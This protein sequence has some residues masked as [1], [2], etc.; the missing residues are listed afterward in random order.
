MRNRIT[1]IISSPTFLLGLGVVIRLFWIFWVEVEQS[2]D[3]LWY[4]QAAKGIAE[5]G[6]YLQEGKATAFF[7]VGYPAF[8]SIFYA[9]FGASPF[10]GQLAN[11]MLSAFLLFFGYDLARRWFSDRI[12]FLTLL[13]LVF[14]PNHIAYCSLLL[15]E[16]L[17][18]TLVLAG[19]WLL[20]PAKEANSAWWTG[21]CWAI[22]C[23]IKPWLIAFPFVLK[24]MDRHTSWNSVLKIYLVIIVLTLPWAYRNAQVLGTWVPFST[25][26]GINLWI[27]NNP[28]ATGTYEFEGEVAHALDSTATEVQRGQQ[29]Y[30]LAINYISE[31]P[32]AGLKLV[33]QKWYYLFHHGNEGFYWLKMGK[34]E[35]SPELWRFGSLFAQIAY[36]LIMILAF[37]FLFTQLIR[38]K[39]TS[40]QLSKSLLLCGLLLFIYSIFFGYSRYHFPMIPFLI[41]YACAALFRRK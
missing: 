25:N 4:H 31:H 35:I 23:H 36:L 11:V 2:S 12:A 17:F 16:L 37:I 30:H 39:N 3:A 28:H 6:R 32:L 26:G 1:K 14:Y 21:L 27:G 34:A 9:L 19:F 15:N 40:F 20:E 5:Q 8:L 41:M 22:A 38:G 13:V 29:A 7:P 18:T 24:V 33:P 10:V